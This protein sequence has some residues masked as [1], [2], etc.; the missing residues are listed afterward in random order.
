MSDLKVPKADIQDGALKVVLISLLESNLISLT[1]DGQYLLNVV[2]PPGANASKKMMEEMA[3]K[4]MTVQTK[5]IPK[6]HELVQMQPGIYSIDAL[7]RHLKDR[8]DD[9]DFDAFNLGLRQ[10][11]MRRE[12][13]MGPNEKIHPNPVQTASTH[14]GVT[15]PQPPTP[16]KP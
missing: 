4:M 3:I 16:Q 2:E 11:L 9:L 10:A 5:I 14:P 15:R 13:F 12:L 7:Y 8:Y 6:V 1:T